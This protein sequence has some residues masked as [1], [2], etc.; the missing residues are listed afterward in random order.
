[1]RGMLDTTLCDK[2]CQVG[3]WFS[4]G[5]PV[6]STNKTD[7]HAITEILLKFPLNTITPNPQHQCQGLGLVSRHVLSGILP[8][9]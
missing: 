6:S 7:R 8:W 9:W 3:R 5:S 2:V 1:M 4:A